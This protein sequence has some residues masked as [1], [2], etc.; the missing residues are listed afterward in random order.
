MLGLSGALSLLAGANAAHAAQRY[1][2]PSGTD[3][4]NCANSKNPC[5]TMGYTVA[6]ANA[7]D[8]IWVLESPKK[9]VVTAQN[10]V[11]D[12]DLVIVGSG[13]TRRVVSASVNARHFVIGPGANVRFQNLSLENGHAT[14]GGSIWN[15][16]ELM[17]YQCTLR[18]NQASDRGGAVFNN[19][20]LHVSATTF[21]ANSASE[22]GG[23]YDA[24]GATLN[25]SNGSKFTGNPADSTGGAIALARF[26]GLA[27][28]YDSEFTGNTAGALGGA[29]EA[30]EGGPLVINDS[31][32][33][34]NGAG[35]SGGAIYANFDS[36]L[37][38]LY[39]NANHAADGAAILFYY[40]D[41][42]LYESSFVANHADQDGGAI[43]AMEGTLD[44]RRTEFASNRA[45]AGGAIAR[46]GSA[47]YSIEESYFVANT[48]SDQGGAIYES[49]TDPAPSATV[50]A[51]TF[52]SNQATDGL[53][54]LGGAV[55]VNAP[56][57]SQFVNCTFFGNSA[58][59]RGGT[60]Y[61]ASA[62]TNLLL[63]NVTIASS[64]ANEGG[65][66]YAAAAFAVQNSV[67]SECED[68]SNS[69]A[70][71]G[72]ELAGENN[73]VGSPW[74]ANATFDPSCGP[75]VFAVQGPFGLETALANN[76]GPLVGVDDLPLLTLGI[77]QTNNIT[78]KGVSGC[79][80]TPGGGPL[81]VDQRGEPRPGG[82]DGCDLGAFE[83]Q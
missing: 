26:S 51:S 13:L 77:V 18:N 38:G 44:I 81:T 19:G 35:S 6:H 40:G 65:A 22:G 78:G 58:D 72:L 46:M 59:G 14:D 31:E 71:A 29:I 61:A 4:A 47:S 34:L 41:H 56:S 62:A 42:G 2:S 69:E 66:I 16:G 17:L 37:S 82:Q 73:L 10:V 70:C 8:T 3:A 74:G 75:N 76:G 60:F 63:A 12:K 9:A 5:L 49:T 39:F 79:E 33:V 68:I 32:F 25:V 50:V 53:S 48:A 45:H 20:D 36:I 57:S 1:V 55:Y 21:L 83:R 11:I 28:I 7:G 27:N 67:F 15:E 30:W 64:S 54:P 23:I 43:A 80:L 24:E 52:E